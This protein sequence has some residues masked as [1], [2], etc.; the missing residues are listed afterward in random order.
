MIFEIFVGIRASKL[1]TLVAMIGRMKINTFTFRV[2]LDRAPYR[3]SACVF[4]S[5]FLIH[6]LGAFRGATGHALRKCKRD[7]YL[8][9]VNWYNEDAESGELRYECGM[10]TESA[11]AH[12]YYFSKRVQKTT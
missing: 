2:S 10:V 5:R 9:W 1:R 11:R 6:A 3:K 4:E 7:Q 8:D 12:S